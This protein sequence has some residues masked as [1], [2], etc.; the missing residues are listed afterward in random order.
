LTEGVL[1]EDLRVLVRLVA[2]G[3]GN[4]VVR[5]VELDPLLGCGRA[6]QGRCLLSLL[7]GLTRGNW[8]SS[9]R[10]TTLVTWPA[11]LVASSAGPSGR[12]YDLSN[13]LGQSNSTPPSRYPSSPLR[14]IACLARSPSRSAS[15]CVRPGSSP[16]FPRPTS[17]PLSI[18]LKRRCLS[19]RLDAVRRASMN[20]PSSATSSRA[21]STTS[22]RRCAHVPPPSG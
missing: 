7:C 1:V 10:P 2:E 19:S 6:I 22:L 16:A 9:P 12:G 13:G 21:T 15:A 5:D 8:A 17:P 14:A 11:S 3:G 4:P 20:W 18:C